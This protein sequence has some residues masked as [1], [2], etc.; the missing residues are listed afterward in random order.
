MTV[1]DAN[2]TVARTDA[3]NSFTGIQTLATEN[4]VVG[5][6]G[7]GIDF[8]ATAHAAGM[9]SELF[10]D[11]EEGTW[12]PEFAPE[13]GAFTSITYN[14]QNGYYTKIG[15]L[16]FISFAL[17]TNSI[18][19]GTAADGLRVSGLPFTVGGFSQSTLYVPQSENWGGDYP[20]A[21]FFRGSTNLISLF[22][23]TS[24]NSASVGVQV[25]DLGTGASANEIGAAGF[26]IV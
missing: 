4:L 6:S 1:P 23:K 10:S 16:V 20:Q 9:T 24:L 25:S 7:K 26:Y 14:I 22:Y 3:A 19:V 12:T 15:R 21:G 17:R 5:T 8:S 18:T 13:T 11:Y 2:F